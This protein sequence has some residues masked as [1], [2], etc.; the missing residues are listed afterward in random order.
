M[1]SRGVTVLTPNSGACGLPCSPMSKRSFRRSWSVVAVFAV[2]AVIGVIGAATSSADANFGLTR[3]QGADRY[4]TARDVA[5]KTFGT[6]D[7]VILAS[8]ENYPDALAASYAAGVPGV[9]IL[10]T[11]HDS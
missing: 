2:V 8:G 3:L 4:D 6:S 1:W 5:A 9:P 7:S 10:L 11:K